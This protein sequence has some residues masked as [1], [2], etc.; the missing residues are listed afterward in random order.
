VEE[1]AETRSG[2]LDADEIFSAGL[3]IANMNYFA[4]GSEIGFLAPGAGLHKWDV[5]FQIRSHGNVKPGNERGSSA[6][7]IFAGSLL[8][9]CDPSRI[10]PANGER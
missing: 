6:A 10:S 5:D 1:P 3:R 2:E 4:F 8:N 7:Q 9:K